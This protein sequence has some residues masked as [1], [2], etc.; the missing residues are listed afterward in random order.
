MDNLKLVVEEYNSLKGE[1]D[2]IIKKVDLNQL[3]LM[4]FQDYI[5]N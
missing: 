4:S 2:K 3:Q 5:E 1:F